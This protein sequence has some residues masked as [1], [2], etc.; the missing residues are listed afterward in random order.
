MLVKLPFTAFLGSLFSHR[1]IELSSLVFP[2][3]PCLRQGGEDARGDQVSGAALLGPT[4]LPEAVEELEPGGNERC[5]SRE[6]WLIT[7]T[8]LLKSYLENSWKSVYCTLK[9][10][11]VKAES[12]FKSC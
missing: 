1:W 6:D 5:V 8:M 12:L 2:S 10:T 3:V 7:P 11:V 9:M 4:L